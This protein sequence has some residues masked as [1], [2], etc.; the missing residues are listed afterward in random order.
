MLMDVL[1]EHAASFILKMEE[2]LSYET[3]VCICHIPGRHIPEDNILQ[4]EIAVRF[5]PIHSD[6]LNL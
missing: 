4:I 1:E 3:S 2:P 5:L 6:A